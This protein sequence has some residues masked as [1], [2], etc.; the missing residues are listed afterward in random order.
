[1]KKIFKYL[2]LAGICTLNLSAETHQDKTFLMSRPV[3][4]NLAM[5]LATF[6]DHIFTHKTN[7]RKSHI[8]VSP[9]YQAAIKGEDVGIYFGIGNGKNC[10]TA[11]D[12]TEETN[13]DKI[14]SRYFIHDQ[15]QDFSK[16]IITINPKQQVFGTRIDYF[17]FLEHPF[18]NTFLKISI[19]VAWIQNDLHFNASEQK[20][21]SDGNYLYDFFS[22][23]EIKQLNDTGNK[24]QALNKLKMGGRRSA[25]GVADIDFSLGYRLV[26]RKDKHCYIHVGV[27]APTGTRAD[28]EYLFEPVY[29][30]GKHVALG[31]GIDA[32]VK[33]WEREHHTGKVIFALNHRYLFDGTEKRTIPVKQDNYPYAHYYLT[34]R[35]DLTDNSDG[36]F[37]AANV[38]TQDVTVRPGNQ[39]D[40]IAALSFNFT[41]FLFDIGYNLFFKE[42]EH[43]TL[44]NW[45]DDK[46]AIVIDSYDVTQ[47][48]KT[49][50]ILINL[51]KENLNPG[52]AATP[53]QL[54]HKIF[55]GLGYKFNISKFPS[56][57]AL[58]ASYEFATANHELEGYAFWG[59]F[60]ISF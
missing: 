32:S 30:N 53:S 40:S 37:P 50:D 34:G 2:L 5:E 35:K 48:I 22:G 42:G 54:T 49:D 43:I 55:G 39:I 1:M 36:I 9:F 11:G 45:D 47:P 28:G 4:V 33:L 51:D 10:F 8:Q 59:K 13:I 56:N 24:Q 41:R 25:A 27:T 44:K 3:G 26:E 6:H 18:K 7:T 46:Y 17:Q 21:D 23:G 20:A 60:I 14:D 52:G 15:G 57:L 38:L 31:W 29:G 12:P 19:P 58:G 16:G